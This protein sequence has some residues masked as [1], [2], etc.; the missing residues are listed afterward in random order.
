MPQSGPFAAWIEIEG[1]PAQEYNVEAHVNRRVVTCWIPSE[2]GKSFSV[3]WRNAAIQIPTAGHVFVDGKECGGRV[4]NGPSG[5]SARQ[6]GVTDA[7]TVRQFTFSSITLTDDDAFLGNTTNHEKLGL[8][9]V[10]IYPI[11]VFG[12]VPVMYSSMALPEIKLHER[13]KTTVTQQVKLAEPKL[14]EVPQTAVSHR[15]LGPPLVTFAF[16]Y[17]PLSILQ[18]SGI[19]PQPVAMHFVPPVHRFRRIPP[20]RKASPELQREATPDDDAEEIRALREK[21]NELEAKRAKKKA[22]ITR[23]KEEENI[24]PFPAHAGRK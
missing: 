24:P 9:E 22:K 12:Y 10:N 6:D 21:L 20:K 5:I 8:I 23:V 14:L 17:R 18:A 13:A 4:L 3:A 19:A 7:T 1:K 16:R 2:V 15:F 11:Q